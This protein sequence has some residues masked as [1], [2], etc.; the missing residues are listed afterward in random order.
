MNL[1]SSDIQFRHEIEVLHRYAEHIIFKISIMNGIKR[2]IKIFLLNFVLRNFK[3]QSSSGDFKSL[4]SIYCSITMHHAMFFEGGRM[5]SSLMVFVIFAF[6]LFIR[7]YQREPKLK[8]FKIDQWLAF[9]L[10]IW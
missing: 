3:Y 5:S 7:I 4:I 1:I 2:S 10:A 6:D 8:D 9:V